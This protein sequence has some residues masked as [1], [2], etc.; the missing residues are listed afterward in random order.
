MRRLFT[1]LSALSL[2]LC[3][4][5]AVLWVRSYQ[6]FDLIDHATVEPQRYQVDVGFGAFTL[7]RVR[8]VGLGSAR[9]RVCFSRYSEYGDSR[10]IR[11]EWPGG[12]WSYSTERLDPDQI[13]AP[14]PDVAV[15]VEWDVLGFGRRH[16]TWTS[17]FGT[18]TGFTYTLDETSLP[19]WLLC[20][21]TAL[22]PAIACAR[23][24][25]GRRRRRRSRRGLCRACGYDLRATPG[26]C[27][28]CGTAAA[29]QKA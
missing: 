28:E 27:P 7:Q 14:G 3:A 29:A 26:R 21:F 11:T 12:G 25:R 18:S 20:L 2:L 6:R 10:R 24:A 16:Y 9:G 4:A 8:R 22:P 17:A 19:H 13:V 1:L 5:V 15:G 23:F